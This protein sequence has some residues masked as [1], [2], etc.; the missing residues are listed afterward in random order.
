MIHVI[1]D[2]IKGSKYRFIDTIKAILI[3][4]FSLYVPVNS[5]RKQN[6]CI[7]IYIYQNDDWDDHDGDDNVNI[8]IIFM[9]TTL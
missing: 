8:I 3:W 4:I 9:V 1:A 7:Y 5:L 6:I 2:M